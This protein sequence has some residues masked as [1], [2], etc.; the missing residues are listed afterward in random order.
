MS[1]K[2]PLAQVI[3]HNGLFIPWQEAMIH[4][5]S[6]GIHYGSPII[7]GIRSYRTNKGV[8]IFG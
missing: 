8:A 1:I 5:L 3:W 2:K 4:I 7:D 6:H